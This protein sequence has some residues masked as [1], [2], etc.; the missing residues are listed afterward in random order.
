MQTRFQALY[1][2]AL[3]RFGSWGKA[4]EAAGFDYQAMRARREFRSWSKASIVAELKRRRKHNLPLSGK[5]VSL[6]DR[7][8][9]HAARRYFGPK[10]WDKALRKIGL[11]SMA[12]FAGRVWTGKKI[13][14]EIHL[15]FQA[16][17]PLYA[18]YLTKNGYTSLV[19]GAAKWFGSWRKAI[20]CAGF[21]YEKIRAVRANYWKPEVVIREIKRLNSL[22]VRLSS[23]AVHLTR[24]DLFS[25]AIKHFGNW[26]KAVEAAGINYLD[27]TLVWS[28]KAWLRRLQPRNIRALSRRAAALSKERKRS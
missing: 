13:I 21:D 14:Q 2:R 28:T 6:Q 27:H 17:S 18:Y 8:L 5:A 11:S 16:R 7:G 9:Y 4:V 25:A 1:Q 26:G 10:G 22:G 20:E 12:I 3:K 15:L 24:G 19:S 23:K